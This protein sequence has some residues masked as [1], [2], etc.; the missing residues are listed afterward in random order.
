MK[1]LLSCGNLLRLNL[2]GN[3]IERIEG[4]SNVRVSVTQLEELSLSA[5]KLSTVTANELPASLKVLDLS[6]NSLTS[7]EFLVKTPALE[8]LN[9]EG[10]ELGTIE[11]IPRLPA[12]NELYLARTGLFLLGHEQE[13][14]DLFPQLLVLDLSD[15]ALYDRFELVSL[16]DVP[17]FRDLNLTGNPCV[18]AP[19]FEATVLED[20]PQL[21]VLNGKP[22]RG[23]TQ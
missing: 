14:S 9:L 3:Q 1:P 15:N 8:V 18:D 22:V 13:L 5:N 10:N 16:A 11:S 12:L 2:A 23:L 6:K 20:Y 4:L 7:V 21:T 17:S 19:N